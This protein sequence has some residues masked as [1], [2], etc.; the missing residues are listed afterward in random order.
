M[1]LCRTLINKL[2][3]CESSLEE[4]ASLLYDRIEN[5]FKK[6]SRCSICKKGHMVVASE[7]AI[8][9][10]SSMI[11]QNHINRKEDKRCRIKED[12]GG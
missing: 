7:I 6:I 12:S 2:S 3:N 11:Y 8:S 10:G 1:P 5:I 4:Q 9:T